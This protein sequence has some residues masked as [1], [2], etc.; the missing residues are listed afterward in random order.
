AGDK[1]YIPWLPEAVT[2]TTSIDVLFLD[3]A[4]TKV[5]KEMLLPAEFDVLAVN[6]NGAF[7]GWYDN[8]EF[9]GE[10]VATYP[11]FEDE[12]VTAKTY[13]AKWDVEEEVELLN[14]MISQAYGGGGNNGATYKNDFIE[15]YNPNDV[16]VDLTGYVLFYASKDGL[17]KTADEET[18]PVL[19]ELSG[20]IKANSFY[21]IQ[22]AAGTGGTVDLP[23]PDATGSIAMSGTGFKLALCNSGVKPVDANSSNVVDFIGSSSSATLYEGTGPAPA[24]S[25]TLAIVRTTLTDTNDN[26]TD[27][28]AAAPAPR[29]SAYVPE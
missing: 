26:A 29:N 19:I 3:A 20:V 10:P 22:A 8:A 1:I 13:Y 17:F 14:I 2:A 7:L 15:L 18:Y 27:F 16:D 28:T 4:I 24:P 21:L 6:P 23:T 12:L 9:T 25:N 5:E 11:G